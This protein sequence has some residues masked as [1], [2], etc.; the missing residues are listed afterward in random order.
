ME[1]HIYDTINQTL[2]S[3]SPPLA[4]NSRQAFSAHSIQV[5]LTKISGLLRIGIESEK[6]VT[7]LQ[8]LKY[9]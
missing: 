1:W 6:K 5:S 7:E 4:S 2:F 9:T 3:V 8:E